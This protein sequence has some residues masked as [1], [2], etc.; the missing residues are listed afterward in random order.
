LKASS[1]DIAEEGLSEIKQESEIGDS[2]KISD[3]NNAHR[4]YYSAS[5]SKN[6]GHINM[7]NE[8]SRENTYLKKDSI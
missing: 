8:A 2:R 4:H 7:R 3:S 1:Y 6:N 5:K